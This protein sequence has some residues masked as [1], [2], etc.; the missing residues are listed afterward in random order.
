MIDTS[1]FGELAETCRLELEP[2]KESPKAT[3]HQ[4]LPSIQVLATFD[5]VPE[6]FF[7]QANAN[8]NGACLGREKAPPRFADR[9]DMRWANQGKS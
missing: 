5:I 1:H 7:L 3:I 8:F 6:F 4:N 2:P 9:E